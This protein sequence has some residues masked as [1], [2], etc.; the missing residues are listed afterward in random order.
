MAPS[1][2]LSGA[3][4]RSTEEEKSEPNGVFLSHAY[5]SRGF[6]KFW[7]ANDDEKEPT[8]PPEQTEK[9]VIADPKTGKGHRGLFYYIADLVRGDGRWKK[10]INLSDKVDQVVDPSQ[11]WQARMSLLFLKL[12]WWLNGPMKWFGHFLEDKLNLFLANG[13]IFK[14]IIRALFRRHQLVIPHRES[15]DYASFIGILDPR[16]ALYSPGVSSSSVKSNEEANATVFSGTDFGSKYTADVLVMASKLAYENAKFVEKV[17]T[18]SWKMNFV[19]FYNCWNEFQKQKNTQVFLFTDKP[20]NAKAIVVAFRGTE[21]FNALDW[22]TD[23]DFS[24]YEMPDLGKIHVGFLEALGLGDR[25]R[26][27]TFVDMYD[28]AC[29][30]RANAHHGSS[31]SGLPDDVVA[32]DDK[33]LAYDDVTAKVKQLMAKNPDAK[34]FLTGHSLGGALA[35]LYTALLFFNKEDSIT[36]RLGALY[37]FGQPRVGGQHYC[38]YLIGKVQ[39]ARYWRVVFGN[40]LV[41]RVPFDDTVFQ[42]KH[43]G[44]CY[45]YDDNYQAVVLVESPNKDYFSWKIS[46]IIGQ[47]IGA[48]Y[49]LILAILAGWKY[50]PE[51]REGLTAIIVRAFGVVTPG[52]TS[53][54]LNNYVNAVRLGPSLLEPKLQEG[55]PIILPGSSF[56]LGNRKKS[57]P[58]HD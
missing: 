35:N 54:L 2:E 6:R 22:S 58:K 15:E 42:F 3:D 45:Y 37:T 48:L 50:G 36:S 27:E 43:C 19:G 5:E 49:S 28:N 52:M 29:D 56:F 34:L 38:D 10:S 44:Y 18:K 17:V 39:E 25:K 31:L 51:Y 55:S 57:T 40:D 30:Q 23:F 11:T 24:W 7:L 41:P 46:T 47:R 26:M 4:G 1:E 32:D 16:V 21:P 20:E 53:H 14:T 9:Y 13:G 8:L 33:K 12:L